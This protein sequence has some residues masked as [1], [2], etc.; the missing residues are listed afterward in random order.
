MFYKKITGVKKR[1]RIQLY[2]KEHSMLKFLAR[3]D[4]IVEVVILH[5]VKVKAEIEVKCEVIFPHST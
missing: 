1:H 2:K 3:T 4:A 5:V